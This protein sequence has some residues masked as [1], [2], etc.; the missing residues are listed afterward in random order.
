[1]K[2][3]QFSPAGSLAQRFLTLK[4]PENILT[5]G[6]GSLSCGSGLECF[7]YLALTHTLA[8]LNCFS[9]KMSAEKQFN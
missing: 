8:L 1:M 7:K 9:F 2:G 6:T 3:H 4:L 5:P